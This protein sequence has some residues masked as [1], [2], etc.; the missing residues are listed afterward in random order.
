M[1]RLIIAL[2]D[3]AGLGSAAYG[4]AASLIVNGGTVQAGSDDSLTCDDAVDVSY[5]VV[6]N[7]TAD[8][9][10]VSAVTVSGIAPACNNNN[11]SVELTDENDDSIAHASGNT[12]TTGSA[13]LG[14]TPS[15]SAEAVE[16]VHVTIYD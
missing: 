4:A 2:A 11:V 1:K 6:W 16:G 8:Q 10:D 9:F 13:T 12:G 5:T 14:V 15:V 7:A 3:V